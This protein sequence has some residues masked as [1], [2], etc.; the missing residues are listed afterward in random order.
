MYERCPRSD[1][2]AHTNT[3]HFFMDKFDYEITS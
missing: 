2:A 1:G 3:G